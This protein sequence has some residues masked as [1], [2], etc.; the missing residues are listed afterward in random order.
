MARWRAENARAQTYRA[1]RLERLTELPHQD[2]AASKPPP[3]VLLALGRRPSVSAF[4][5]KA[6]GPWA[7]N[8]RLRQMRRFH[9]RSAAVEAREPVLVG[10]AAP[11]GGAR[12][13][14]R[15]AWRGVHA[16]G[17][18]PTLPRATDERRVFA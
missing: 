16:T 15:S 8:V 14:A 7:R 13:E 18:V 6:V 3:N 10:V 5:A 2:A 17:G 4:A 1:L 11:C 12:A 9:A